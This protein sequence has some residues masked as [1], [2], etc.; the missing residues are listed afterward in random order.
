MNNT[1][2]YNINKLIEYIIANNVGFGWKNNPN[3]NHLGIYISGEPFD[4]IILTKN[5]KCCFDAKETT[6]N[7]WNIAKKDIKQAINLKKISD[8]GIDSFFLIYFKKV[9]LVYKLHINKFFEILVKRKNI[10]IKDC[11]IWDCKKVFNIV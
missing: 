7:T 3:R 8:S 9:N 10:K 4:Y 1:L 5:Y 11:E 2:E 6:K